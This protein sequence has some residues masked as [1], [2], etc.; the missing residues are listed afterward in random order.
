MSRLLQLY[1]PLLHPLFLMIWLALARLV[2]MIYHGP[3]FETLSFA[4]KLAS[5]GHSLRFDISTVATYFGVLYIA[6]FFPAIIV[7]NRYFQ[8][9]YYG[10]SSLITT[11]ILAIQVSDT[12]YFPVSSRHITN[13][14]AL[15]DNDWRSVFL[16][17]WASYKAEIFLGVII[18]AGTL[19]LW[20]LYWVKLL[21]PW[22]NAQSGKNY[23]HYLLLPVVTI[24]VVVGV[25]G[26]LTNYKPLSIIDASGFGG[27]RVGKLVITG[28]YSFIRSINSDK[29]QLNLSF[30]EPEKA[31]SLAQNL[32]KT[33]ENQEFLSTVNPFLRH[34]IA[35]QSGEV[36]DR[37]VLIILV[38]SFS[39]YLL[40]IRDDQGKLL[41]PFANKLKDESI[42]FPNFVSSG[43]RS[44]EGLSST[45]ACLPTYHNLAFLQSNFNT[46]RLFSATEEF[47]KRGISTAFIHGGEWGSFWLHPLAQS[48]G[49]NEVI[50]AEDFSAKSELNDGYWGIYDRY[51]LPYLN[52]YMA[53]GEKPKFTVFF[54]L[55]THDPFRYDE[56]IEEVFI[57]GKRTSR[58]QE[59]FHHF[60]KQLEG[61]LTEAKKLGWLKNTI[62]FITAD[63]ASYASSNSLNDVSHIPL[64]VLD[65]DKKNG[66]NLSRGN[67]TSLLPTVF[68]R[69][70]W[71]V[72]HA[73]P[74]N[75][76][77]AQ[78]KNDFAYFSSN[79]AAWFTNSGVE[80]LDFP[81]RFQS[82]NTDFSPKAE[83]DNEKIDDF[84]AF[85]Q[86]NGEL[87]NKNLIFNPPP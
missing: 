76:L 40:D 60:D 83:L 5:F 4:E 81:D 57:D 28:A 9:L 11:L 71:D 50:S 64:F 14:I 19:A 8:Y 49:M 15:I 72:T 87:L 74:A 61:F 29:A 6:L 3:Y 78:Q 18:L 63:H 22:M 32:V 85:L 20:H 55:S 31:F 38:E 12:I 34:R 79:Q 25:R 1:R 82:L 47:N 7:A 37:S 39:S 46:N 52:D 58:F 24:L 62:V 43:V 48:L 80:T 16:T 36:L 70:N 67:Q 84:K 17:G 2:F 44:I 86:V 33:G 77:F 73:C 59:S 66:I 68:D 51:M 53:K 23:F 75:S 30:I 42:F 45:L 10:A 54:T 65:P 69:L 27:D 21:R 13:E 26:G 41:M 56:E 35:A